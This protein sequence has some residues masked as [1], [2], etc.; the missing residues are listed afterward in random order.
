M[1]GELYGKRVVEAGR[2]GWIAIKK[3]RRDGQ[4]VRPTSWGEPVPLPFHLPVPVT[5]DA[6]TGQASAI[7]DVLA[8]ESLAASLHHGV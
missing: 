4:I 2:E 3:K 6:K 7:A 1:R 8:V 5:V